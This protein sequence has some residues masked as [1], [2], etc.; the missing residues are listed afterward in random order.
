MKC[1]QKEREHNERK[2]KMPQEYSDCGGFSQYPYP[3]SSDVLG[4]RSSPKNHH[5]PN[6]NG[7]FAPEVYI[8]LFVHFAE[9]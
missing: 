5:P 6:F 2:R 3:H 7:L 8:Q 9:R 4:E 1:G